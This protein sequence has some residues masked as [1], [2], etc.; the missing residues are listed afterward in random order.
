MIPLSLFRRATLAITLILLALLTLLTT[1]CSDYNTLYG[2][3]GLYHGAPYY[4]DSMAAPPPSDRFTDFGENEFIDTT[5]EDTST[6]SLDINTASYTFVR[7]ML[8]DQGQLPEPA[9]VRT[10]EFINFFRFEY[11]NPTDE[12]FS[13]NME[14][15][16]SHFGSDDD[17]ERHL[18]RIGVRGRDIPLEDMRATNL[19]FLVDVSG[20]MSEQLD[21]AKASM[22]EVLD[23]LRP[24]DTVAIQTY[25]SGSERIL[26]PTPVSQRQ[27]IE[28][29]INSLVADGYTQG[30]AAIIDAYA[31]AEEAFINDGNNRVVI[32]TDGDFNVGRT[33]EDLVN[34]VVGFREQK[35]ALTCVG[36]GLGN[37]NDVTMERLAREGYGNYFYIDSIDEARRIFGS[38]LPS[39][40]EVIASDVRVQVAFDEDVVRR[41]R[42]V[43]YEKRLL[44]NEDFEREDTKSAE[45]GPGHTV[46][47]F[48]EIELHDAPSAESSFL[49]DVKVRYKEDITSEESLQIQEFV[50]LEQVLDSF[51]AA[52]DG[53]RFAAAVAHFAGVLRQSQYITDPRFDDILAIADNARYPFN[54]DQEEFLELVAT[55]ES[56]SN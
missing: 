38:E 2:D 49:A 5:E 40:L 21:L 50:K 44:D 27:S 31:M 16:P 51:D 33:G 15:A 46:T 22:R 17:V 52:S 13:I 9:Q 4:D 56:L 18:L 10:E 53:F 30:D 26:S 36:F 39:T 28:T 1:G 34:L 42:L 19:V 3:E 32:L 8:L 14:I 23:H 24:S 25:A 6:F 41:Y 35:I 48:Y 29:A 45:I 20:S 11:P 47:A 43:G 12:P 55:A 37:Y 54:L 7:G